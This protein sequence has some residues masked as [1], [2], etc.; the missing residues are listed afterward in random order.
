MRRRAWAAGATVA[1]ASTGLGWTLR[2]WSEKTPPADDVVATGTP[3]DLWSL[4]FENPSG[5]ELALSSYAGRSL[6]LNFWATW[7]PPCVEEL[8]LLDRFQHEHGANGWQ[9]IG[10]A[11]DSV[12]PVRAFL[13]RHPVTFAIGL[14]GVKGLA[15]S[16]ALGNARGALPFSAIVDASGKVVDRQLGSLTQEQLDAWVRRA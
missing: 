12:E 1:A 3:A 8:P 5:G 10:L 7:C 6:V 2:W 13:A 14:A 9:V 11:V 16:R 15:L 4:R